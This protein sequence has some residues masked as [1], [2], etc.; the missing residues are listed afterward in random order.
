MPV[1][2]IWKSTNNSTT[3]PS[4]KALSG[5]VHSAE[6]WGDLKPRHASLYCKEN[7]NCT[8][9]ETDLPETGSIADAPLRQQ[10]QDSLQSAREPHTQD[11][12][13]TMTDQRS[14]PFRDVTI[15]LTA[16]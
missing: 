15:E 13:Q 5:Q 9:D 7:C 1:N 4:C 14:N 6:A 12:T 11:R 16:T 8:L 10:A 2:W 3:C